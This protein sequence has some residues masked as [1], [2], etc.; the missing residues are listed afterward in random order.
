MYMGKLKEAAKKYIQWHD[1]D[2][3]VALLEAV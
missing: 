1:E 2:N 3:A